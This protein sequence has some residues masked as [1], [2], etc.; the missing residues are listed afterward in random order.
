MKTTPKER[1]ERRGS[2]KTIRAVRPGVVECSVTDGWSVFDRGASP[3]KL[4]GF[5]VSRCA[6]ALQSFAVARAV[7][8]PTHFVRQTSNTSFLVQEFSVPGKESLSGEVH[9][10]VLPLEFIFRL[11]VFGSLGKRIRGGHID[12]VA[13]GFPRGT[14]ATEIADGTLLPSPIVEWTTKFEAKDRHLEDGEAQDM[15]KLL[16]DEWEAARTLVLHLAEVIGVAYQDVGFYI[17]DGKIELGRKLDGSIVVVDVFGTQDECRIRAK[18][19]DKIYDKDLLRVALERDHPKWKRELDL[20][21]REW[22]DDSE[23]WPPYPELSEEVTRLVR[24]RYLEVAELYA[25]A[26]FPSY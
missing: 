6:C 18:G 17:P 15:A 2:S 24:A 3:Q 1:P 23:K 8:I 25:G 10:E 20:A 7:G 11:R 13:F 9:G 14:V 19:T 21:K 4:P 5:G 12:P 22:S 16:D 26:L